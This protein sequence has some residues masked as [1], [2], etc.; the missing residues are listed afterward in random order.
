MG[1][2]GAGQGQSRILTGPGKISVTTKNCKSKIVNKE[3]MQVRLADIDGVRN[4]LP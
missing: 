4:P 3:M 1:I 2:Y